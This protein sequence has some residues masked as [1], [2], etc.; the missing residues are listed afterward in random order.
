MDKSEPEPELEETETEKLAETDPV[1]PHEG[2]PRQDEPEN[3]KGPG[4]GKK[5]G[6]EVLKK[7]VEADSSFW[8]LPSAESDLQLAAVYPS[9]HG[10][11]SRCL[12]NT[13]RQLKLKLLCENRFRLAF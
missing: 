10:C 5:A 6:A 8:E 1:E 4:H 13:R 9:R 3:V 2:V 12:Q 11:P 7:S